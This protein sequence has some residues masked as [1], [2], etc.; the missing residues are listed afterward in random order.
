MQGLTP[1]SKLKEEEYLK[2]LGSEE[3]LEFKQAQIQKEVNADKKK[4]ASDR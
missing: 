4:E 2:V 1:N 3:N